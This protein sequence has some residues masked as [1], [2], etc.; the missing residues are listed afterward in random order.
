M[1]MAHSVE[2][3]YPFLD[4]RV[5]EFCTRLP[6][7]MKLRVLREKH[8]LREASRDLIPAEVFNRPKRPYRAPIQR[9]FFNAESE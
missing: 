8:I 1:A 4:H 7:R 2:G 5:V 3:R 9:S 6:S